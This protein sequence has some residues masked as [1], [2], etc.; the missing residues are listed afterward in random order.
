MFYIVSPNQEIGSRTE[1][2][3]RDTERSNNIIPCL[4]RLLIT[5]IVIL[6]KEET[7]NFILMEITF[8]HIQ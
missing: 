3:V 5:Q 1:S 4:K 6:S 8:Y 2:E 7:L